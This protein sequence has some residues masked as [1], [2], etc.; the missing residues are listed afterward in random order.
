MTDEAKSTVLLAIRA[1]YG[2][3]TAQQ[4]AASSWLNSFS[5]SAEAW[6]VAL[7]LLDEQSLEASFFAANMLLS[8]A[9]RDWHRLTPEQHS[10]LIL[11]VRYKQIATALK[12]IMCSL[13]TIIHDFSFSN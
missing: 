4:T 9:R 3:D 8:K 2:Q 6:P 12:P 10:Q 13:K 11:L 5:T 7:A 1:L